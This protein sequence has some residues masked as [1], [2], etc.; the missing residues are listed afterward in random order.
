MSKKESYVGRAITVEFDAARCIHARRCVLGLPAVFRANVPGA[1]IEPDNADPEELAA[2]IRQ[3]PSGA[4]TFR[5]SRGGEE[6][7]P[8]KNVV[9]LTENGPLAVRADMVLGGES[10]GGRRVLCRCGAS[11]NKPYCDGSHH[12]AGFQATGEPAPPDDVGAAEGAGPLE[13]TP[14]DNGP[15]LVDGPVEVVAASGRTLKRG[16]KMAL[17][18]CGASG[19]KPYCDGSHQ[20]IGFKSNA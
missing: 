1:W 18:R 12:A 19:N 5:A 6:R 11:Q 20:R 15:L 7:R 4:L 10:D 8:D 9:Q 2:L 3:C 14:L 16:N 17:C 13:V